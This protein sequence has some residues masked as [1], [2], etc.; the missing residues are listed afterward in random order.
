MPAPRFLTIH[1]TDDTAPENTE[2]LKIQFNAP[3]YGTL[4]TPSDSA[5]TLTIRDNDERIISM[6]RSL[7]TVGEAVG[8][9]TVTAVASPPFTEPTTIPVSFGGSAASTSIGRD[10]SVGSPGAFVFGANQSTASLSLTIVDDSTA[11]RAEGIM[12]ALLDNST[13]YKL[14]SIAQTFI[15]INDNDTSFLSFATALSE[16]WENAGNQTVSISLTKALSEAITIPLVVLATGT[17]FATKNTD[18]R[19]NTT[20]LT[21]PRGANFGLSNA[22]DSERWGKRN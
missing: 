3:A 18:F 20:S 9:Y 12:V 16:P 10:Y 15:T 7:V 14:G 19:F 8:T 1:L 13:S 5:Y 6:Q 17:G 21:I 4:K 11:E 2:S 22:G